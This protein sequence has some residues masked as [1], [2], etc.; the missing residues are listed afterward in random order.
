MEGAPSAALC[1]AACDAPAALGPRD[2]PETSAPL[3][4]Q[5]QKERPGRP[6][7]HEA[8]AEAPAEAGLRWTHQ[9]GP[10]A[11]LHPAASRLTLR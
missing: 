1:V 5:T 11:P 7:S 2:T 6:A 10:E 4:S 9:E 3:P 8:P